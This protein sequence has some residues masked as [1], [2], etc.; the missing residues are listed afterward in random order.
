[1][2]GRPANNKMD[3]QAGRITMENHQRLRNFQNCGFTLLEVMIA[4]AILAT[5]L[6]VVFQ[7]QSQS[8]SMANDSRSLTVMS[9]LAQSKMADMESIT[10]L[11]EGVSNGNFGV[12]Y[13][14]YDWRIDISQSEIISFYK[15]EVVVR[16]SHLSD[17]KAYHLVFYRPKSI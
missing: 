6:I 8:I 11:P 1:M 9:L 10:T 15:V 2:Y 16:N 12:D 14:D 3:R 5:T 13:P 17:K 4:M 7:S